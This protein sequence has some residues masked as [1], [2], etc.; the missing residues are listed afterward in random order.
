MYIPLS[1][2]Q[3]HQ[4]IRVRDLHYKEVGLACGVSAHHV[5]RI[6]NG[7]RRLTADVR[8]LFSAFIDHVDEIRAREQQHL[9][10]QWQR[11]A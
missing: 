9:E 2:E 4:M 10:R 5:K 3:F 8:R 7:K 11:T 6:A 1:A